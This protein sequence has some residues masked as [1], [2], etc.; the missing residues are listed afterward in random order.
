M[1]GTSAQGRWSCLLF[2]VQRDTYW[3][4]NT[5]QVLCSPSRYASFSWSGRVFKCGMD[6]LY[7]C[8]RTLSRISVYLT[9]CLGKCSSVSHL[10]SDHSVIQISLPPLPLA[11]VCSVQRAHTSSRSLSL[12]VCSVSAR[13]ALSLSSLASL[14]SVQRAHTSLSLSFLSLSLCVCSFSARTP[15]PLLFPLSSRR[16]SV[17][18]AHYLSLSLSLSLCVCSVAARA[19]QTL[20]RSL[21]SPLLCLC[22]CSVQRAHTSLSF[23]LSLCV[24]SARG[25]REEQR[26]NSVKHRYYVAS[27]ILHASIPKSTAQLL[28]LSYVYLISS[29]DGADYQDV[30]VQINILEGS[31]LCLNGSRFSHYFIF[32]PLSDNRNSKIYQFYW[33]FSFINIQYVGKD[34]E[35]NVIINNLH[36]LCWLWFQ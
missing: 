19:H 12:C 31:W 27:L 5:Q 9:F 22:V 13:T 6:L 24:C 15:R 3:A 33:E 2:C 32:I 26:F 7:F 10:I 23:S 34:R 36:A 11:C 4:A 14:C 30:L 29:D 17:Q 16:S 35:T 20:S 21:L 28:S 1:L 18:R 25:S 8:C